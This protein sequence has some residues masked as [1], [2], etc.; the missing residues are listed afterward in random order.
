MEAQEQYRH[1]MEAEQIFLKVIDQIKGYPTHHS[2]R[3]KTHTIIRTAD[4]NV[5]DDMIVASQSALAADVASL[6]ISLERQKYNLLTY[7]LTPSL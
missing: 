2:R 7:P 6:E 3:K 4:Q 1:A 5:D